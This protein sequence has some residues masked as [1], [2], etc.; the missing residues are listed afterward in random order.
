MNEERASLTI[1]ANNIFVPLVE[2]YI[3]NII[4]ALQ[5]D[6]E[7]LEKDLFIFNSKVEG[8]IESIENQDKNTNLKIICEDSSNSVKIIILQERSILLTS[9]IKKKPCLREVN[10]SESNR[11]IYPLNRRKEDDKENSYE[12]K[13]ISNNDETAGIS[14]CA[15]KAYGYTYPMEDIY[16][17]DNLYHLNKA[18]KIISAVA[19]NDK[20]DVMGHIALLKYNEN[21]YEM[22]LGFINPEYRNRNIFS[23]ISIYLIEEAKKSNMTG[24]ITLAVT[25][26]YYSQKAAH[27][28]GLQDCAIFLGGFSEKVDFK[29]I[30]RSEKTRGSQVVSYI[31]IKGVIK[32]KIYIPL[33]HK[34]I[35]SRI[36][37]DLE[38]PIEFSNIVKMNNSFLLENDPISITTKGDFGLTNITV[39][40]YSLDIEEK[41]KS[42]VNELCCKGIKVIT[43]SLNLED[44]NT[45]YYTEVFEKI[46]FFFSGILPYSSP[47]HALVL[48]YL[49]GNRIDFNKISIFYETGKVILEYVKKQYQKAE[50]LKSA[51]EINYDK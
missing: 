2:E 22:G 1:P 50:L 16:H 13:V 14:K 20:N 37:Q 48:Q 46:G 27:N 51:K 33:K 40:Y 41:I 4:L 42:T 43:L 24:I 47:G 26:H 19:L 34:N 28:L 25:N 38:I 6:Y 39:N 45:I 5:I 18:K 11:K 7:E 31:P 21:I 17:P 36:F 12:I 32:R 23:K 30:N 44:Y 3:K 9:Y 29:K 8:I 35:I 49:N 15:Y 10:N